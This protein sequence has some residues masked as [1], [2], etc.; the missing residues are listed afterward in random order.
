MSSALTHVGVGMRQPHYGRLL[1][2]RP[3]LDFLEVHSENFFAAGGASRAV[4]RQARAHYPISLH[5]VGLG[6]GSALGLD[7]WHLGKLK[8][9]AAEV[10]P[11]RISD[12]A[13]FSRALVQR[14]AVHMNDLL[15]IA[16]TLES[17]AILVTNVQKVQEALGR[18]I[19]VENISAYIGWADQHLS[20]PQFFNELAQRSGCGVLLDVNNL[21]VNALNNGTGMERATQVACE[22]MDQLQVQHV[23]QMHLAG[24]CEEGDVVIDDHGSRVHEPV[25][26]AYEYAVQRFGVLPTLIEWDTD[27]P[28]LEVLLSDAT[29]ACDIQKNSGRHGKR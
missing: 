25:W 2:E 9:L 20:E 13:S 7:A 21:V 24:Y 10:E 3:R 6:L 22:W 14:Q 1:E 15:P 12:H 17:L 29:L 27:V 19:L 8:D 4:L 18:T 5:G 28:A 16:F 11:V 26:R 23:G